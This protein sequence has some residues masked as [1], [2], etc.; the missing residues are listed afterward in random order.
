MNFGNVVYFLM[1]NSLLF[2]GCNTSGH[3]RHII[4]LNI[5]KIYVFFKTIHDF[6]IL[7]DRLRIINKI[8]LLLHQM[9]SIIIAYKF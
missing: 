4:F 6:V 2:N 7:I 8:H 9:I 3:F 1:K 5:T